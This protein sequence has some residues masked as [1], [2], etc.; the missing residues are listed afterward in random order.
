[1]ERTKRLILS[2][3]DVSP[4]HEDRIDRLIALLE[5][6]AGPARYAMLVV[7]DFHGGWPLPRFPAFQRRLRGWAEAGVE[8][9]LHGWSHRD[10]TVHAGAKDRWKATMMTAG[11]G[12]F[13]GLGEAEARRRLRDGCALLEDVVG[14]PLAGFVAP[15]WHYGAGAMAAIAAEGFALAEDH[16]KVWR[17]ADGAVLARGPVI[18]Y[19]SRTPMRLAS[20]LVVSRAATLALG[21]MR[22][23]RLAV[24]PADADSPPLI[25]EIDRALGV[26]L[27]RR[28]PARYADLSPDRSAPATG[29]SPA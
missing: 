14:V 24:H 9:F 25:A 26:H 23:L 21:P 8:M 4:A 10:D 1:L 18:T 3:H 13:L 2:I 12:E 19:A 7:P 20:S 11:E 16:M 22:D 6:R 29:S 5:R 17:P 27:R 28:V 15:A